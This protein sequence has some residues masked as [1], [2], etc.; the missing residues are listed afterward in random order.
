MKKRIVLIVVMCFLVAASLLMVGCRK[1]L[2]KAAEKLVETVG[3]A[4]EEA[5]EETV[6]GD[7]IDPWIVDMRQGL[8]QYRGDINYQGGRI[9]VYDN[10]FHDADIR[11]FSSKIRKHCN[12][13]H[14]KGSIKILKI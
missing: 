12:D 5:M 13:H 8:D 4:I 14:G 11:V 9:D 10:P 2:E 1:R 7:E 6:G 3:E